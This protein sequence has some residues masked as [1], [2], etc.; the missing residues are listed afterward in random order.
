M[1]QQPIQ[2]LQKTINHFGG[3][4]FV[5]GAMEKK[6]IPKLIDKHLGK[7]VK[8]ATYAFSD[9]TLGWI[10][11][12]L[13]GAKRIEDVNLYREELN[14]IP[15]SKF[16][17]PDRI[18]DIMKS[19]S[20]ENNIFPLKKEKQ[21]D[22]GDS[23]NEINENERLQ[24]LL[25]AVGKKLEVFKPNVDYTLDYDT[26]IV[27]TEKFDSRTTYEM[28][29]GYNPGIGLINKIPVYIHGRNGNTSPAYEVKSTLEKTIG[30]L[31]K[32][33]IK[34]KRARMDA[35]SYQK[36]VIRYLDGEGIEFFIRADSSEPILN[37][38]DWSNKWKKVEIKNG[39]VVE[40]V[41]TEYKFNHKDLDSYRVVITRVPN[42]KIN[43]YT[44]KKFKYWAIITNNIEMTDVEVVRFYNQRGDAER[45][46]DE[47]MNFF[48]WKR[49][50]FSFMNE[51]LVFMYV[52]AIAKII[53]HYLIHKFSAKFTLLKNNFR[54]KKFINKFILVDSQWV[55]ENGKWVFRL[56]TNKTD[57]NKLYGVLKI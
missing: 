8:Q 29:R 48:N 32:H 50:P 56:F 43:K 33:K 17:S 36:D 37:P 23:N 18:A 47:M 13:C 51:N 38:D 34:V 14:T 35:A 10:Y 53:Y 15:K 3:I 41:S 9:I 30:N 52:S 28:Y 2:I 31:R 25:M 54:L 26:M 55:N 57:Y 40:M 16:C 27:P 19:F 5:I 44:K 21:S 42:E 11:S 1:K 12:M 20:T 22:K 45:K 49:L 7:R 24:D 6:K 4:N 39:I 46:F